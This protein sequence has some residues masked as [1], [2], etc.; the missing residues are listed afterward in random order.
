MLVH[1]QNKFGD[2][3]LPECLGYEQTPNFHQNQH[4]VN[5]HML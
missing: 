5:Y 1:L 4:Q 3:I 2:K